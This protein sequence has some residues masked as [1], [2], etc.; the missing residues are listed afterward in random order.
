MTRLMPALEALCEQ[1]MQG[2]PTCVVCQQP[3]TAAFVYV[4][5]TTGDGR[6]RG[7]VFGVCMFCQCSENFEAR[8]TNALRQDQA[9]RKAVVWN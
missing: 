2:R 4:D 5:S 6:M 1:Y 8:V 9:Q 3:A 7:A